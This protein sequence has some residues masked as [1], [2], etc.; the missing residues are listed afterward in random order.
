MFTFKKTCIDCHFIH[1]QYRDETG[2]EYKMEITQ[3]QR[4]Q[5]QNNDFTWQKAEEALGCYKGVWDKG[6]NFSTQDKYK[7]LVKK[8]QRQKLLFLPFQPG[9]FFNAVEKLYDRKQEIRISTRNYRLAI[10]TLILTIIGLLITL[11]LG[12]G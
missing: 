5:A 11:I 3:S 7:I 4:E 10:Y 6:H 8:K 2:R 9:A 1:R 12:K